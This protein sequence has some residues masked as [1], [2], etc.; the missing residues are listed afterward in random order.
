MSKVAFCFIVKDGDTYLEK[1]LDRLIELGNLYFDEFKIFYAENDSKDNTINILNKYKNKY[2]N[3]FGE[4]LVLDGKHSTELCD[5]SEFNCKKRTR[6]LA[7]LRNII[8]NMAKQWKECDYM[9]MLDLDFVDFDKN[10][11]YNMFN[12]IDDNKN[13]NGIFGMSVTKDNTNCLYDIG[14]ITPSN[15]ILIIR[16]DETKLIKVTSAFSGF[17]IYRMK[18]LIDNNI[19]YNIKTNEIE[20]IDFNRNINNLYVY[21]LYRPV[22]EGK[23]NDCYFNKGIIKY[24]ISAFLVFII[25]LIVYLVNNSKR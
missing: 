2:K 5:N 23:C 25:I 1:N 14:A 11:F 21:A 6:R 20:H 7:Y 10:E 4:H 13:I 8:L 22:Y 3:I 18:K 16:N 24:Y 9:I 12:I 19:E 17:G 15:N